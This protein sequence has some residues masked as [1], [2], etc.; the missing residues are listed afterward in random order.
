[1]SESFTGGI[2]EGQDQKL[3]DAERKAVAKLLSDPTYFPIEF[4]TWIK[5]YIEGSDI[6]I[7]ASQIV[8]GGETG[9]ERATL[10]PPGIIVAY[11]GDV[12]G[13]DVL[14]CNGAAI[15][16]ETYA[17]LFAAIGVRWGA[18]DGSTTFAVPDLRDRAMYGAGSL[19]QLAGTDGTALGTRGP[20]HS[21][22]LSG[23]TGVGS[24]HTHAISG[25]TGS[26][27]DHQHQLN[28]GNYLLGVTG[29]SIQSG[30]QG[31]S[32]FGPDARDSGAAGAHQHSLSASAAPEAA[33]THSLTGRTTSGN[34]GQKNVPAYAGVSFCITT[35]LADAP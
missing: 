9:G 10:L 4:R 21:H 31:G 33:H 7:N 23:N 19:V 35:G 11:A 17:A 15:S 13:K 8:A 12:F 14:P 32:F 30:T 1:M 34:T 18:G 28:N 27:G 29:S 22:D 20:N 24:S 25:S 26:V 5:N 2:G 16:R 6:R 3:T